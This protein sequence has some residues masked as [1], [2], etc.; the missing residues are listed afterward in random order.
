[1]LFC[2]HLHN[3]SRVPSIRK[4]CSS[5]TLLLR[6]TKKAPDVFTHEAIKSRKEDKDRL[7][8]CPMNQLTITTKSKNRSSVNTVDRNNA[9]LCVQRPQCCLRLGVCHRSADPASFNAMRLASNVAVV[10]LRAPRSSGISVLHCRKHKKP[11]PPHLIAQ[12][13]HD[14]SRRKWVVFLLAPLCPLAK[15]PTR[16]L[17]AVVCPE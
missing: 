2:I 10:S 11:P 5:S 8:R 9:T 17:Y 7:Y 6:C 4:T 16:F 15:R 3:V 12:S 1:M 13:L 14:V